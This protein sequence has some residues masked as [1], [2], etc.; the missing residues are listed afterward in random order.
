[1]ARR[2]WSK[3]PCAFW[4]PVSCRT[5][6]RSTSSPRCADDD[7]L[8]VVYPPFSEVSNWILW[9]RTCWSFLGFCGR[10]YITW[11][12]DSFFVSVIV[13]GTGKIGVKTSIF[14]GHPNCPAQ[15]FRHMNIFGALWRPTG[16]LRLWWTFWLK[17]SPITIWLFNIA[18][19]HCPFI[20]GLPI[21]NGIFPWLC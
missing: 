6:S 19:E 13:D 18:T 10:F 15:I 2:L 8:W 16:G 7:H 4:S 12:A 3:T 20:D 14:W 5:W 21:K 17:L 9:K 11:F 1:M